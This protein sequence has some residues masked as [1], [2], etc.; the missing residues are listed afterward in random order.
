MMAETMEVLDGPDE[1]R[2]LAAATGLTE[3]DYTFRLGAVL[4]PGPARVPRKE[5][6]AIVKGAID[7]MCR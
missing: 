3:L 1:S 5:L 2:I 7:V 4:Q 6:E